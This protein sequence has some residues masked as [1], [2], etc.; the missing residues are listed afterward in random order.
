MMSICAIWTYLFQ[1]YLHCLFALATYMVTFFII[2]VMAIINTKLVYLCDI[3]N[4]AMSNLL[5]IKAWTYRKIGDVGDKI[6]IKIWQD[7]QLY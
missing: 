2:K 1:A 5:Q 6:F 4:F 3:F 7:I